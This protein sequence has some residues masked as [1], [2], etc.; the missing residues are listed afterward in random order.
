MILQLN[1]QIPVRTPKGNAQAFL[2]I[3]YSEE[4]DLKW[5]VFQD[6]TGECWAW[7]NK[8]IRAFPNAT[9]GRSA[10]TNPPAAS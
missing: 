10:S 1:P 9:M 7:S 6:D 5:V 8:E 3:D 4:H 2:I